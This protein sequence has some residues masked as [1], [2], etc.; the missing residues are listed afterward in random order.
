MG[1]GRGRKEREG[2]ERKEEGG[3]RR[4]RGREREVKEGEVGEEGKGVEGGRCVC[5]YVCL[6]GFKFTF[7]NTTLDCC[8]H[9]GK[10]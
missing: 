2:R 1:G 4:K 3:G 8:S 6:G 10:V 5:M 7:H 9:N